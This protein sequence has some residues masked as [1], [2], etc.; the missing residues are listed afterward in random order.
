[1]VAEENGVLADHLGVGSVVDAEG[2]DRPCVV[3]DHVA[4]LPRYGGGVL[5]V[6][7]GGAEAEALHLLFFAVVPDP[8]DQVPGAME[9]A[10]GYRAVGARADSR[11][12]AATP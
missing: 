7:A 1:M 8:A 6:D 9:R 11:P 5:G 12:R 3:G 2:L 4:V 10:A